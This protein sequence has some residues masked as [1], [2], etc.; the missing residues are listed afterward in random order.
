[1]YK[2]Q[3][4]NTGKK[5]RAYSKYQ[6]SLVGCF[7]SKRLPKTNLFTAKIK[8]EITTKLKSIFSNNMNCFTPY[9]Y[10]PFQSELIVVEI[11]SPLTFS[12]AKKA[13]CGISTEP[14]CF[15]RFLP[16]FCFSSN[17][18]FLEISPP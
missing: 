2:R 8:P 1:V 15:I 12:T 9:S 4:K 16:A 5:D 3:N 11:Y 13:S 18:R 7:L 14:I 17:F 6:D 10:Q